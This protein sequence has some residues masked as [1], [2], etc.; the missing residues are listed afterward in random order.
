M[1]IP[2]N[3]AKETLR[4]IKPPEER[5]KKWIEL[6]TPLFELEREILCQCSL[7]EPDI[8][9][10]KKEMKVLIEEL[11][12]RK[13]EVKDKILPYLKIFWDLETRLQA[14]ERTYQM[15]IHILKENSK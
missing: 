2:F 1:I 6:L 15:Y 4:T 10:S 13:K 8:D 11:E 7:D 5:T 9:L 3:K 12:V 14:S